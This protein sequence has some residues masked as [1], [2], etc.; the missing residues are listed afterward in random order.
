MHINYG[1]GMKKPNNFCRIISILNAFADQPGSYV[2]A[3]NTNA[4]YYALM[5]H[6]A[7]AQPMNSTNFS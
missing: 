1:G 2:S 4:Q 6:G 3:Q 5:K 7:K